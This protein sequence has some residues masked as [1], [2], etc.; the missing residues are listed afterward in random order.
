[1]N[2]TF[3]SH[4]TS[5]LSGLR[6]GSKRLSTHTKNVRELALKN[7]LKSVDFGR[8]QI[9][10]KELLFDVGSMHDLG[11]YTHYFQNYL[12]G[13][14]TDQ[15]LKQHAITGA[16]AIFNKY[17][18]QDP[19]KAVVAYL[20]IRCH[21]GCLIDGGPNSSDSEFSDKNEY[22]RSGRAEV[23]K[24]HVESMKPYLSQI[25]EEI[26]Q[27]G[28]DKWLTLPDIKR[29]R[30]ASKELKLSDRPLAN[31]FLINYLFSLLIE[32]DKLDA[33]NTSKYA[34]CAIPGNTV[35]SQLNSHDNL[36]NSVRY[37]VTE[38]LN[39]SSFLEKRLFTLTAP[40]GTG[41]TLT[42]LDFAIQLRERIFACE[43]RQA[44]I[45]YALPFINIIEQGLSVY[46]EMFKNTSVEIL[47]HYQY[48]DVF[49]DTSETTPKQLNNDTPTAYNQKLMALDTW[50]SDIV[51]T[52]F[53]QFFETLITNKNKLLK[54]F[55]HFAG[56]IIILDEVQTIA[57][58]KM[59]LIGSVLHYL[60]VYLDAR[61]VLMTATRPKIFELA[62]KTILYRKN[63]IAQPIELLANFEKVFSVFN[64]T[65][66]VPLLDKDLVNA[67]DFL[68]KI[69]SK[70]WSCNQSSLIVCNTVLRSIEVFDFLSIFL[71]E[72]GLGNPV[73]YLS[74]NVVPA[75]RM[76]IIYRIKT[77]LSQGKYP[78][79]VATQ[80][81]EAGVDIDFDMGVRDLGPIDS[82][83]QVAGRINRNNDP[84]KS[85]SPLYII[86]FN[87]CK[88]IYGPITADRSASALGTKNEF[89]ES[90][91][92]ELIEHYFDTQSADFTY[93]RNIFNSMQK[94]RYHYDWSNNDTSEE[95]YPVSRFRI[96]EEAPMIRSVFIALNDE[97]NNALAAYRKL[98]DNT[99]TRQEFDQLFK[100]TFNQHIITVPKYYTTDLETI[101]PHHPVLLVS[102]N[103]IADRYHPQTGYIRRKLESND[104]QAVML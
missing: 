84:N 8:N 100:R 32:S 99:M 54:K 22:E 15:V 38:N 61:V 2:S 68:K 24:A 47:A 96:I 53:V 39:N 14:D 27:P 92:L 95:N 30:V 4:A 63:E 9:W 58:E 81:V 44:Q 41:K 67:A 60:T 6:A 90:D 102:T 36:R 72:E 57:F 33:S 76:E 18:N 93:S 88:K 35:S 50:Q 16:Y 80:V 17:I 23:F 73:Y 69:F 104:W 56:A 12:L 52:S 78:I 7:L 55:H 31:Y 70:Y 11:K 25:A 82:I 86:N 26:E 20:L 43:G 62:N 45:I 28:L 65:K 79:L 97:A 74:T 71:E 103:E 48:A 64:R 42:S 1:M 19:F 66:I 98:L 21:H 40:T 94:L 59:P 49:G 77:D 51:I 46:R 83:V 29:Y 10:I 37:A 5:Q 89:P 3:Y 13:K 75:S 34:L 87:D 101:L 91:Y 85:L